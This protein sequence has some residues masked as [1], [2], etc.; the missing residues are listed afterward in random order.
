MKKFFLT[1][2]LVAAS[3]FARGNAKESFLGQQAYA[4]MQRVS[5]EVEVIRQ[6]IADLE[7]KISSSKKTGS[8]VNSL[9]MEIDA[10]KGVVAQLRRDMQ[11]LRSE[12]VDD[13]VKQ[14]RKAGA[15][16][17]STSSSQHSSSSASSYSGKTMEYVV[18]KGDTLSVIARATGAK[19]SVIKKINNLKSDNLKI[20]QVLVIPVGD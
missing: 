15:F 1:G 2:F 5:G 8:E 9:K 12:I 17:V 6:N 20:G 14:L 19:V 4:E 13:I 3:L 11:N 7:M 18:V 10:L 16:S